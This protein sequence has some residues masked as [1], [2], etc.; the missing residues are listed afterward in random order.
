MGMISESL[1]GK[2]VQGFVGMACA[3]AVGSVMNTVQVNYSDFLF[4][5]TGYESFDGAVFDAGME[6]ELTGLQAGLLDPAAY[7]QVALAATVGAAII[8]FA[9][10]GLVMNAVRDCTNTVVRNAAYVSTTVGSLAGIAAR[11]ALHPLS[12]DTTVTAFCLKDKAVGIAL[13][14]SHP[15]LRAV[16]ATSQAILSTAG[17][18]VPLIPTVC[19]VAVDTVHGVVTADSWG[20]RFKALTTLPALQARWKNTSWADLA[21]IGTLYGTLAVSFSTQKHW[22]G[23]L[24]PLSFCSGSI[25]ASGHVAARIGAAALTSAFLR[26]EEKAG[27]T[28]GHTAART[29]AFAWA[30][31][32]LLPTAMTAV[33]FHTVDELAYGA[34]WG[35]AAIGVAVSAHGLIA[36]A[37][38]VRSWFTGK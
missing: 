37:S 23:L 33:A 1:A 3:G 10:S 13:S 36:G 31:F 6:P 34:V 16:N 11:A 2:A 9:A 21:Y 27:S 32:D 28:W 14:K 22:M 35:V 29:A 24:Q 20:G 4:G 7:P 30:A 15:A 19:G 26:I 12:S 17:A 8:G 5:Q 38:R 25:D 18:S